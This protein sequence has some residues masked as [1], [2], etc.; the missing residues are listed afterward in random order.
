[1]STREFAKNLR[2][3]Q[4]KVEKIL[5]SKI[6]NRQIE[7]VKFRRQEPIN[8]YIVDFVCLESKLI[9]ELDGG[10]HNNIQRKIYDKLRTSSLNHIG[11]KV[12]R[13]WNSEIIGNIDGVLEYIRTE[14]K[15]SSQPSPI[16]G[17]GD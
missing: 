13:I 11:F 3:N 1:M 5:W 9:L 12:L 2:R 7:G 16:K 10:H 17:E 6:R 8:G 14:V 15:T 4:T